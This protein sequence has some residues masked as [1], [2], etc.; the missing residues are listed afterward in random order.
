MIATSRKRERVVELCQSVAGPYG[1]MILGSMGA[2]VTKIERPGRGD[3]CRAWGPPFVGEDSVIFSTMNA[4]KR[5]EA[6]D[7]NVGTDR[8]RLE[9]LLRDADVVIANWRPN[10]LDDLGFGAAS[11]CSRYPRIVYCTITGFGNRGP[12]AGSPGY[13]PILQAFTGMMSLTGEPGGPPTRAGTSVIDMSTGLWAALAIMSALRDRDH[14]GHGAQIE[15]SLFETGLALVPYQIPGYAISGEV[16]APMGSGF[17]LLVPYQ[18]FPTSTGYVVVAV[19]SDALWTALT[20][21]ISRT[22]LGNDPDL[23][24]NPQRV[25]ARN[26]VVAELSKIFSTRSTSHWCEILASAGVPSAPVNSVA[27]VWEHP[28]TVAMELFQR[29]TAGATFEAGCTAGLPFS[30]DGDRPR[31]TGSHSATPDS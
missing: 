16:P 6:L 7:L 26:R 21:A 28:Q 4:G 3:D 1:G 9:N 18:A 10:A 27:E 31:P 8:T 12:L 15:C 20:T 13:D 29:P 14:S 23:S 17:L 2:E 5:S 30:T 22:D 24:T 25:R 19:G 11:V